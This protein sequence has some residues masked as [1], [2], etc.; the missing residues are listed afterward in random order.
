MKAQYKIFLLAMLVLAVS[1][2][3]KYLDQIPDD[4][5]TVEGVFDNSDNA[6]RFLANVYS[7]VPDEFN[8]R[9]VGGN[10][11]AG[12]WTA[13]SDE[14][15][16][17]WNWV[18]SNYMNIGSWNSSSSFVQEFWQDD[19]NAI[20]SAT[21]FMQNIDKVPSINMPDNLKV[22]Y[23]NEAR[24]LRAIYYFYLVRIYG[25][26][27]I[28]GDEPIAVDAPTDLVQ[29]PRNSMDECIDYITKELDS[30]ANNLPVVQAKTTDYGRITKPIALAFKARALLLNASPLFNGN[31]D[32]AALK[33]LDGKQ[34]INQT[35]DANKWKL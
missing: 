5:L 1:S 20:R 33:N 6:L 8:Q 32:Y 15:D 21:F 22:I 24:A 19:Y 18:G 7:N 26:I 11:N 12:A 16:Y 29:V 2:C 28:I 30:A 23:K 13:A 9:Y 14:A 35:Y 3:K 10:S 31:S 25:P 27:V 34:L 17:Q 4:T